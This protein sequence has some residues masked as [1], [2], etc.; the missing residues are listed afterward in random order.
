MSKS[1]FYG[2]DDPE[3]L[4]ANTVEEAIEEYLESIEPDQAPKTLI[5]KGYKP[6]EIDQN[7][8][9]NTLEQLGENLA[10][11]YGDPSGDRDE[12]IPLSAIVLWTAFCEQIKTHYRVWSCVETGEIVEVKTSEYLPQINPIEE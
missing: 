8:F 5:V 7:Y 11:E 9:N 1:I 3:I 2:I 10:D 6:R 4:N 12:P